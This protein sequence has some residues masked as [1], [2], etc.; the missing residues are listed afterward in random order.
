MSSLDRKVWKLIWQWSVTMLFG[1]KAGEDNCQHFLPPNV[2]WHPRSG[3][4]VKRCGRAG[5][6]EKERVEWASEE[7]C[8][9]V[10][11]HEYQG[12]S[13]WVS[14][15]D[16]YKKLVWLYLLWISFEVSHVWRYFLSRFRNMCVWGHQESKICNRIFSS[17]FWGLKTAIKTRFPCSL[18]K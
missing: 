2:C 4:K 11:S 15:K 16:K 18:G 1:D 3:R 7:L 17:H 6:R 12:K 10:C 8:D 5:D 14:L 13:W 9:F